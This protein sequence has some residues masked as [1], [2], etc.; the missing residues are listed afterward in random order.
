ML[1]HHTV[2]KHAKPA[3][4]PGASGARRLHGAIERVRHA[5]LRALL[6]PMLKAEWESSREPEIN[7]GALQYSFALG[8]L[9]DCDAHDVL[10]V[11]TGTS[12]WPQLLVGCGF[13]VTA[14]D[15]IAGYWGP[16]G[17]FNRHFYVQRAD[18]R[19]PT[20][21]ADYDSV[22]C[23]N[24]MSTIAE[25]RAALAGMIAALNPGGR[26][27][28]SFPY[29]ETFPVSNVYELP[30]AGYGQDARY[31]CRIYSRADI[32]AWLDQY[33]LQIIKQEYYRVFGGELWTMGGRETPRQV[34]V[35]E[36]HH[37]TAIVL[38]PREHERVGR[39]RAIAS[40]HLNTA[41]SG[42]DANRSR[43]ALYPSAQ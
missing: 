1:D 25:D 42:S 3:G 16:V 27:V 22:T 19:R 33:G 8:A 38:L 17:F 32:D 4:K 41:T 28:L 12:A 13:R 39:D 14:I 18:V 24:V 29:N 30:D 2:M 6:T 15:E 43:I 40:A 36:R 10:D 35:T 7:E 23:L 37:F 20:L 34:P 31:R 5:G 11:G 26:L 9:T 21:S